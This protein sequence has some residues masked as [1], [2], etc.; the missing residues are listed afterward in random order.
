MPLR[1]V[2]L[3]MS[4]SNTSSGNAGAGGSGGNGGIGRRNPSLGTTLFG[5][6]PSEEPSYPA[7]ASRVPVAPPSLPGSAAAAGAAG[8]STGTATA[9]SFLRSMFGMGGGSGSQS[10][11][12]QSGPMSIRTIRTPHESPSHPELV[13]SPTDIGVWE[14]GSRF[15]PP[16]PKDKKPPFDKD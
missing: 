6:D 1:C 12:S 2:R 10:H 4:A 5:G 13:C 14:F 9:S 11:G 8:G 7:V 3:N 16:T 15:T